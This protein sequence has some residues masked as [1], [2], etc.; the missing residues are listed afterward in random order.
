MP[1]AIIHH[2]VAEIDEPHTAKDHAVRYRPRLWPP[3]ETLNGWRREKPRPTKR[4]GPNINGGRDQTMP[5]VSWKKKNSDTTFPHPN[6]IPKH[7]INPAVSACQRG[8]LQGSRRTIGV[9]SEQH[10]AQQ[11]DMAP[12]VSH[13]PT[14]M[15]V[16][17]VVVV[18]GGHPQFKNN[19]A[20]GQKRCEQSQIPVVLDGFFAA[21]AFYA[22]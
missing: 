3:I 9:K 13:R 14:K 20:D 2:P 19:N 21:R 11:V 6:Q 5:P 4:S 22:N 8:N 10:R 17:A 1:A 15:L 16:P 18:R 12:G 7:F